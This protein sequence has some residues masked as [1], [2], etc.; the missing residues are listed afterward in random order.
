MSALIFPRMPEA[1]SQWVLVHT[2]ET[3]RAPDGGFSPMEVTVARA[4]IINE[5]SGIGKVWVIA[6]S[7]VV[8]REM[9]IEPMLAVDV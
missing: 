2:V 7:D 1:G 3:R 6:G 9:W 4:E 8:E 5:K